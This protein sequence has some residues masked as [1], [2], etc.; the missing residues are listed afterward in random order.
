MH[1][2]RNVEFYVYTR[3]FT[4]SS[5]FC[6]RGNDCVVHMR[7]ITSVCQRWFTYYSTRG[8]TFSCTRGIS[9]LCTGGYTHKFK[10]ISI[11]GLINFWNHVFTRVCT[12]GFTWFWTRGFISIRTRGGTPRFIP[13]RT[14]KYTLKDQID[15]LVTNS[16]NKNIRDLYRWVN[17]FK[18]CCQP[19]SNLVEDKNGDLLAD[20]HWIRRIN[21]FLSYWMYI[22]Q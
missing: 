5:C 3:D 20:S 12:R 1:V 8:F 11:P 10:H 2:F 18:I 15:E 9:S 6:T 7:R 17:T 16:K 14:C 22:G 13:L 21:T 4:V 19:R